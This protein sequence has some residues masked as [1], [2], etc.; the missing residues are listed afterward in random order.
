MG[1]GSR[2]VLSPHL[3]VFLSR[4]PGLSIEILVQT[5]PREMQAAGMDLLLSADEPPAD[6]DLVARR[7]GRLRRGIY[8]APTYLDA[9]TGAPT[10]PEDLLRHRCL[11]YKSPPLARPENEWRF[12]RGGRMRSVTVPAAVLADDR[13]AIIA[14]ALGGAGIMRLGMFDP[15]LITSGALV[16]L[17]PDWT[18]LGGMPLHALYRRTMHLPARIPAFIDFV[19]E[20]LAGFDPE[21]RTFEREAA[22]PGRG[23]SE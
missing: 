12:E 16:P 10:V 9:A 23:G 7:L 22:R 5:L 4:H 3:G 15:A 13:T 19:K 11:V 14:L 8:A 1:P 17:L 2:H 18:C 20:C 6:T 21:Q